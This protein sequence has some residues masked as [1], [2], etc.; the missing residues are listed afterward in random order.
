MSLSPIASI[1]LSSHLTALGWAFSRFSKA[2]DNEAKGTKALLPLA[3]P[4]ICGPIPLSFF[5]LQLLPLTS[6]DSLDS[7]LLL[8]I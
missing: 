8:H 5:E 3:R 6:F 4:H 7:I 1:L 2:R